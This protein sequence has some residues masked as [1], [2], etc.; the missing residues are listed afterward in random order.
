MNITI[1]GAGDIGFHLA[2]RLATDRHDITVVERDAHRVKRAAEQLDAIVVEGHGSSHRIL[3]E[4]RIQDSDILAAM[5]NNDEVNILACQIAKKTGVDVCIARVRNPEYTMPDYILS[6]EDLG[7]DLVIHPEKETAESVV[8][9][10]RQSVATDVID[11]AE[12][13][14]QLLGLRLEQSSPILQTP[15]KELTNQYQHVSQ[16]IVAISRKGR[17]LIPGG[18]DILKAGD[19]LYII[20]DPN[21]IPEI[22][23]ITGKTETQIEDVMI[24]GGGLVG[25][26]I[27]SQLGKD[28]NTKVVESNAAR[29]E[30]IANILPNSLIIHGDGTDID[31]LATEGLMDMDA[32]VAVTGDD[33]TNIISTLV[34]RHLEVPRTIAL[35]NNVDYLPITPTIGM[36]AVVSKQVITVNAVERFIRHRMVASLASL[37]EVDAEIIEYLASEQSRITKAPLKDIRFPDAAIVGA[38]LRNEEFIIPT[39]ATEIQPGDKVVVFALPVAQRDVARLFK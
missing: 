21:S 38:V 29:S 12:G 8:R 14:A 34:A 7:V 31:L 5:T 22:M 30:E 16:R 36:D 15:L 32:F 6:E 9:L 26:F 11:F 13:K 24:L 39:G 37:P 23:E 35:V 19:Q 28:I 18:E 2:K 27:A 3:E 17:T 20:C 10:I 33:E 25:Q 4:A 1:I